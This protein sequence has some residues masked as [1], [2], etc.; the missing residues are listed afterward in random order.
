M[1]VERKRAVARGIDRQPRRL[2][3]HQCF[4]V[5]EEYPIAMHDRQP[6]P[7]PRGP[8]QHPRWRAAAAMWLATTG[9]AVAQDCVGGGAPVAADGRVLGHLPYGD[10][11]AELLTDAPEGF[12]VR[13]RCRIRREVLPDLQRLLAAA[14]GD[15]ATGGQL[16]GLSCHRSLIRQSGVFCREA[17]S[18]GADRAISV[19]PP[20]HSEHTTG[21][22]IDFAIRPNP[23]CPDA[24]ACMAILPAARWLRANAPRYGFEMS[25]PPGNRQ[26]VK[27]EPWHWRW[28]GARLDTPGAGE[29]RARFEA[30][31]TRF[32]ADPEV[33][34]PPPVVATARVAPPPVV[35]TLKSK[36][37]KRRR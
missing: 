5:D 19:A 8:R 1:V 7:R 36:R 30:A 23:N 24:E 4:A 27:W 13:G 26:G 32:P 37:K 9:A 17:G 29:A 22:A 3:D 20:G 31:R 33:V 35:E 12:A 14:A 10:V 34:T 25:F 21:Y 11:P 6:L 2:V 28:V 15:P 16:R 18:D